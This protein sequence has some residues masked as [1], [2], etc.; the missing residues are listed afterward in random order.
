GGAARAPVGAAWGGGGRGEREPPLS[1]AAGGAVEAPDSLAAPAVVDQPLAR[2]AGGVAGPGDPGRDVDRDDLVAR[3]E[4][5]P[6]DLDEV[7][8]R[9]L[10]GGRALA[11]VPEP[12]EE[13]PV[14]GARDLAL[15][16]L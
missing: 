6:V 1:A 3:L 2:L 5:R 7:A 10:R 11:R 13:L 14:G 8:D 15:A 9:R 4:Q 12:L 16:P